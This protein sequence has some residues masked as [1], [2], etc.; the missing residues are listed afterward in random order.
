M[1]C[2]LYIKDCM[3][4]TKDYEIIDH[5]SIVINNSFIIE[6]GPTSALDTKYEPQQ[7]ITATDKLAM[8][9]FIDGHTHTSQQLLRGRIS[10]EY[11]VI[12][13]RFNIPYE[14]KLTEDDIELCTEL[15]CLEM[16]KSGITAFADAGSMHIP[17]MINVIDRSGLRAS[18]TPAISDN[19]PTLPPNMSDT[20]ENA[21]KKSE[22]LFLEYNRKCDGR[23]HIWFQ[24]RSITTCTSELIRELAKL[25]AYY[26]TGLHTHISEYPESILQSLNSYGMREIKYLESLDALSPNLLAAH[27]ILLSEEDIHILKNH[28]VKIVH[29]PRS[30]LGKGITKTPQLLGEG[31]SVGLGTDGTAHS[32][33]NMFKEMTAFKHSQIAA[34]GVPY[35]D[36]DVMDSKTLLNMATLGSAKAMRIDDITGTLEINKKADLILIDMDQPHLMPTHSLLNTLVEA[37]ETADIK[38]VIVNGKILMQNREVKVLDEEHIL[39]K[40]KQRLPK[41]ANENGWN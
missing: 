25:A 34:W 33:L 30:N 9:G 8:P 36:Y 11:P 4:L 22:N 14:S 35:S 12:Y 29:C 1:K 32:G 31:L 28:D 24:F 18:I 23:I 21:L 38:D 3:L 39:S 6:M 13:R 16:I 19:D 5:Q 40:G 17:A 37:G 26:H 20:K 15:S 7:T 10:D 27:C 2:D 41:I